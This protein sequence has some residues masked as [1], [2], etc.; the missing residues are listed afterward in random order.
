[1]PLPC[2]TV[3]L[4]LLMPVHTAATETQLNATSSESVAAVGADPIWTAQNLVVGFFY[5]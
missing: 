4:D 2:H 5:G 3:S 1:M